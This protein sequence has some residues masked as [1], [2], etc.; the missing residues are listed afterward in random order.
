[1]DLKEAR[2][3]INKNVQSQ[4]EYMKTIDDAEK[5]MN[6]A[7]VEIPFKVSIQL[8]MI[9]HY[10]ELHPGIEK[11]DEEI[12]AYIDSLFL[13]YDDD[14]K[15]DFSDKHVS[16]SDD[17]KCALTGYLYSLDN[18]VTDMYSLNNLHSDIN[19]TLKDYNLPP[20]DI[21][22]SMDL[23]YESMVSLVIDKLHIIIDSNK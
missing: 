2:L 4:T 5:K 1:M 14:V 12:L 22:V 18:D 6:D 7:F 15:S 17:L 21:D 23:P 3:Q 13:K 11:S 9:D 19:E 10:R 16:I 20:M 8:G